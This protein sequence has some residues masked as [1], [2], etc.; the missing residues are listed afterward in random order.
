MCR[1][2]P[3]LDHRAPPFPDTGG[4]EIP[5]SNVGEVWGNPFVEDAAPL[6]SCRTR[7]SHGL[8][9]PPPTEPLLEPQSRRLARGMGAELLPAPHVA[10]KVSCVF[11][12]RERTGSHP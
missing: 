11:P 6:N 7:P 4:T 12:G 10:L 2:P 3:V 8:L 1:W 9:S 5:K